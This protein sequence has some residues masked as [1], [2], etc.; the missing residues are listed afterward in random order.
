MLSK[1]FEY[2]CA[3]LIL[4]RPVVLEDKRAVQV[5]DTLVSEMEEV[6]ISKGWKP[7]AKQR[8]RSRSMSPPRTTSQPKNSNY[9]GRKNKLG[10]DRTPMKCFKCKCNHT[11]NCNCPCVYHFA[12]KCPGVKPPSTAVEISKKDDQKN[13]QLGLFVQSNIFGKTESTYIVEE[14]VATGGS[15][16]VLVIKESLEELVCLTVEKSAALIDCACPSTVSGK[17]WM[18]EF[19]ASLSKIDQLKVSV[20]GSEKVYKFGGGEKR[21]SLG[22][23]TFPCHLADKNVKITTEVVE[24]DFPLLVGNTMLKKAKAVLFFDERKAIIMGNEVKMNETESGHFSLNI[25]IPKPECGFVQNDCYFGSVES[26][27]NST[28]ELNLKEIQKLHHYFGHIPKKKLEDLIQ[29]A[30]KLTDDVKR[31]LEYVELHCKSC[32]MNA[33]WKL[34]LGY[35]FEPPPQYIIL[36]LEQ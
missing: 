13:P 4:G 8:R 18:E 5:S 12:D 21:K 15:D 30:N 7:P 19:Y 10:E 14:D 16:L 31:H 1:K 26:F 29:K 35:H 36:V 17:R 9:K 24:A 32:K 2:E 33:D 3:V 23:V 28:Q 25:E 20:E 11:E 34:V 22:K 6:L 27:V